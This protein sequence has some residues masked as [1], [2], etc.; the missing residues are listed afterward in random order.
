LSAP[1]RI[2][3]G[4]DSREDIAFQVCKQSILDNTDADVEVI[5]CLTAAILVI[6]D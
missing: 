1:L 3:V 4:W 2:Y 6:L 5:C